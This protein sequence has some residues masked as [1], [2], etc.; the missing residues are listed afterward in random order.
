MPEGGGACP[1]PGDRALQSL[2]AVQWC[3]V[4]IPFSSKLRVLSCLLFKMSGLVKSAKGPMIT[5]LVYFL[6]FNFIF[7]MHSVLFCI[8]VRYYSLFLENYVA[9]KFQKRII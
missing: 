1:V 2:P 3:F 7:H 4:L 5:H 6:L 9:N 8:K